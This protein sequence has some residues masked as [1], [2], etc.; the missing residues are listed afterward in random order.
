MSFGFAFLSYGIIS[1]GFIGVAVVSLIGVILFLVAMHELSHYY[2]APEIF[3]NVVYS[4]ITVIVGAAI[5]IALLIV[6]VLT[7]ISEKLFFYDGFSA[8]IRSWIINY[9]NWGFYCRNC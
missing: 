6:A 8:S 7:T 1:I 4:I 9:N 3:K 5:F 2:N